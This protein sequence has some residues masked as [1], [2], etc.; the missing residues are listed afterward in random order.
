MFVASQT[1]NDTGITRKMT[2][3]A[4]QALTLLNNTYDGAADCQ[5]AKD[6]EERC[7]EEERV[8]ILTFR[9]Y[10]NELLCHTV[11]LNIAQQSHN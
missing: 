6:S 2:L 5:I 1:G 9:E 10:L 11:L 4:A 3:H 7:V 8:N